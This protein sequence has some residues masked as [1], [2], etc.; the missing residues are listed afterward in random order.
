MENDDNVSLI[1]KKG[2]TDATASFDE[3]PANKVN[4]RETVAV[5]FENPKT[6]S[7]F[8]DR[9][10]TL[11]PIGTPKEINFYYKSSHERFVLSFYQTAQLGEHSFSP[12]L[13]NKSAIEL[14][15]RWKKYGNEVINRLGEEN[16]RQY[17]Y[18]LR[19]FFL[20]ESLFPV[21]TFSSQKTHNWV[22]KEGDYS[23]LIALVGNIEIIKEGELEW[24]QITEFRA[25]KETRRK[26]KK[27]VHWLDGNLVGKSQRYI[28]DEIQLKYDDYRKALKKHGIKTIIGSLSGAFNLNTIASGSC[29]TAGMSFVMN[30][31]VSALIGLSIMIGQVAIKVAEN[32][33]QREDITC[34]NNSEVSYVYE[35]GKMDKKL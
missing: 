8:F 33:V 22:F 18:E 27:F 11:D 30:Q 7:L 23:T 25:D 24:S 14:S 29:A 16:F 26:Y 3:I 31:D 12:E 17:F 5:S 13:Y 15:S 34:G 20:A 1:W 32:L 6:A 9:V 10:W 2:F 35:I 28:E 21:S 4:P 19:P